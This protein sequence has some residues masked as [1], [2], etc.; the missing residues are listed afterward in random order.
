MNCSQFAN[1][2]IFKSSLRL[3]VG[4]HSSQHRIGI[5]GALQF[6]GAGGAGVAMIFEPAALGAFEAAAEIRGDALDEF[7]MSK[8]GCFTHVV[9]FASNLRRHFSLVVNGAWRGRG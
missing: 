3:G 8:C 4:K 9:L 6:G 7:A 1:D 2:A 5:L